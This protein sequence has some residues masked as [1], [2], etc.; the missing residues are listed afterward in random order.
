MLR[1]FSA[2]VS[3]YQAPRLSLSSGE[4]PL[5]TRMTAGNRICELAKDD[6]FLTSA[7][8][9]SINQERRM[10]DTPTLQE[11]LPTAAHILLSL[12]RPQEVEV[13]RAVYGSGFYLV[14]VFA[15]ENDRLRYLT[16][17]KNIPFRE[18]R[19]LMKRD[20]EEEEPYGQRSRQTFQLI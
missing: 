6:A 7:A 15:S 9:A 16:R 5:N 8:I 4:F 2:L 12:K 1:P 14:G 10:S 19:L 3:G 13:L 20:E 18:A 17:D 11:P